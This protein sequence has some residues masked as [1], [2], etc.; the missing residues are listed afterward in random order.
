METLSYE[1]VINAP[2]QKVWDVL[3]T[4]ETY[5]EWT[6]FFG[7]GSVMKSDW[8][9][10]GKTYFV[11]AEGEGMV[12]TIDSIDEPNQVIFK[13]LGMVDKEGNEDIHSKEV[14][15]W[16]GAF[17]KYILID[18]EGKTKLHAEVQVDKEWKDHLDTGF[19]KGLDVVKNLAENK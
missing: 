5:T 4:P 17:E 1:I 11:N 10:G 2:L 7:P 16:S 3:W 9:V 14:M 13:H 18:L 15:E 6:Q 8:E 19:I 12:S